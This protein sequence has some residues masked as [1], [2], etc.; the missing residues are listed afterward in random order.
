MRIP[1][2]LLVALISLIGVLLI[3]PVQA[4]T[5]LRNWQVIDL[6]QPLS[7][8]MPLWSDDPAIEI[9]PWASYDKDGYFINRLT[10]GE[11][12]GTHWGT[13]N[14][15]IAGATSAEQVPVRKL[16]GPAVVVDIRAQAA[17]NPDYRLSLQ[18]LQTWEAA[19]GSVPAGSFVLLWTG[20][21]DRW[22]DPAAFLNQD[23]NGVLHF[24]GFG[25]EVAEFLVAQRQ[26]AGLGTDTHGADP[27]ND[28]VYGASTAIYQANGLILECL[29][30]LDQL[31][32]V[33][34]T[35]VIGGLPIQG[36]SG[37][38]ARLLALLPPR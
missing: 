36:G 32:A 3:R 7:A 25:A 37:S 19:H 15:F 9:T 33:G 38:P 20:W 24:P 29:G 14:T 34:T 11:H 5:S 27:G 13:A 17:Q 21:Q 31:P 2:W 1:V 26:I 16:V 28:Q 35:L 10:I 8:Q 4:Q 6:T 23:A 22:S 12:S 30:G 18:D